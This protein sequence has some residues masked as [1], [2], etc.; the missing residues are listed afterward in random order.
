M[1]KLLGSRASGHGLP[2]CCSKH[3]DV[4]WVRGKIRCEDHFLE[5]GRFTYWITDDKYSSDDSNPEDDK[6]NRDPQGSGLHCHH[7]NS[8]PYSLSSN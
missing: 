6:E 8:P 4:E 2:P 1:M 5:G 7:L 3:L